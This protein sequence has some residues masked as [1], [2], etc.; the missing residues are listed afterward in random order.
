MIGVELKLNEPLGAED[1]L[2]SEL[3]LSVPLGIEDV[4]RA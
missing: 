2:G 4:L 1:V 3:R